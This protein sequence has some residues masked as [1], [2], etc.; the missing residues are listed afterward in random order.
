[1]KTK[2]SVLLLSF[3]VCLC[4]FA[5]LSQGEE[6]KSQLYFVEEVIIPP[7]SIE[8]YENF[9]KNEYLEIL[10]K[11][12]WPSPVMVYMDFEYRYYYVFPMKDFAD[13]EN[14]F[15]VW[16][17]ILQKLGADKANAMMKRFGDI[18][19]Y[20]KY[21]LMRSLPE[22]SYVPKNPR[23]K[24]EEINYVVWDIWYPI[25][26]RE[27]DLEKL[28]KKMVGFMGSKNMTDDFNLFVGDVGTDMPAY[29]G[30]GYGKSFADYAVQNEKMWDLIGE[31]GLAIFY[32]GMSLLRKREIRQG[33]LRR[34]LSY[35]PEQ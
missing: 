16:G 6:Q 21:Y 15:K 29:M 17:E 1:M 9:T 12:K 10:K 24:D 19:N 11:Y 27:G 28:M 7:A 34:D 23:L 4:A 25:P 2:L 3:V 22:L 13:V 8:A 18:S 33:Y 5:A 31:E 20:Y 30:V 35:M 14:A 26:G 32:E